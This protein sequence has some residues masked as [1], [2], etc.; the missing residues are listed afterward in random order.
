MGR[1][2]EEW[3]GEKG[4]EKKRER[5]E[6]GGRD[7][8]PPSASPTKSQGY[9]VLK[10]SYCAAP[11]IPLYFCHTIWGSEWGSGMGDGLGV[12]G[13]G[14]GGGSGMGIGWGR[15]LRDGDGNRVWGGGSGK[16]G[17]AQEIWLD[18]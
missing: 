3:R 5:K 4:E 18:G 9:T 2:N 1:K 8:L 17:G 7:E 16:G 11:E 15:V 13:W 14:R 6:R 12:Q 10:E